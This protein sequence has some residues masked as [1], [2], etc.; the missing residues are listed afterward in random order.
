MFI[1]TTAGRRYNIEVGSG[2]VPESSSRVLNVLVHPGEGTLGFSVCFGRRRISRS[3]RMLFCPRSDCTCRRPR[4]RI[5]KAAMVMEK[6]P[7]RIRVRRR[8]AGDSG[9]GASLQSA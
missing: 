5:P 1:S 8:R 4:R 2:R 9:S 3:W 7:P 6:S